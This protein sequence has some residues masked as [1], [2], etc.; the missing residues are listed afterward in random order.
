MP[1]ESTLERWKLSL[2][3]SPHACLWGPVQFWKLN[4]FYL[5]GQRTSMI[6]NTP[7]LC[8]LTKNAPTSCPLPLGWV[9]SSRAYAICS[10]L[11][12]CSCLPPPGTF[13]AHHEESSS[14]H[15][16]SWAYPRRLHLVHL[17]QSEPSGTQSSIWIW[18]F[19]HPLGVVFQ[20]HWFLGFTTRH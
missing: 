5:L 6:S 14:L 11:A 7:L 15:F 8:R 10:S 9:L 19:S 18:F 17:L 1:S 4:D 16:V 12:Q 13:D 2:E 20:V 3:F